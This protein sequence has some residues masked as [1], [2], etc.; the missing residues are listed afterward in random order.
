MKTDKD[1]LKF[2]NEFIFMD[3][4][5]YGV[6]IEV[7][8]LRKY[9]INRFHKTIPTT[10]ML[11]VLSII[12]DIILKIFSKDLEGIQDKMYDVRENVMYMLSF[13]K[14]VEEESE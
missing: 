4:S 8:I 5:C 6:N 7:D 11:T 2:F 9:I 12:D 14:V 3:N 13:E 1:M 10:R